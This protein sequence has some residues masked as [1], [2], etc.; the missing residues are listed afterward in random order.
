MWI[1][2]Y[3]LCL[4]VLSSI[5]SFLLMVQLMVMMSLR[6]E[7]KS[8]VG[9]VSLRAGMPTMVQW[10]LVFLMNA[11][12]KVARPSVSSA[13]SASS[14]V[15]LC[16]CESLARDVLSEFFPLQGVQGCGRLGTGWLLA[17][18]QILCFVR[19]LALL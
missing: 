13:L 11:R 14:S 15:S 6:Y 7:V 12:R 10:Q 9:F 3:V 1:S 18:S 19:T 8:S 16:D 5:L 17:C 4:V 2:E